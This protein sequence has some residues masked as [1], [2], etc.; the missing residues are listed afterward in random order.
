MTYA[1]EVAAEKGSDIKFI[2][3]YPGLFLEDSLDVSV[4][5]KNLCADCF[6]G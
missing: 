5:H 4:F 3:V 6:I 1:T 2:S